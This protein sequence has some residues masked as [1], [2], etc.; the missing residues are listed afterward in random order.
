[1]Q[2]KDIDAYEEVIKDLT[3]VWCCKHNKLAEG[4]IEAQTTLQQLFQRARG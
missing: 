4:D 3:P 2:I 1:M